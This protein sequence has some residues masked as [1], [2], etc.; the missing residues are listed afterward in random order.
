MT[1]CEFGLVPGPGLVAEC[2][3]RV[4]EAHSH[5]GRLEA[6]A[7]TRDRR[8][9]FLAVFGLKYGTA[10]DGRLAEL[11]GHVMD[12]AGPCGGFVP[13]KSCEFRSVDGSVSSDWPSDGGPEGFP[14]VHGDA[15][16]CVGREATG[17]GES[18]GFAYEKGYET[19][20]DVRR[21]V[22]M[23]RYALVKP[24]AK[25]AGWM[26]VRRDRCTYQDGTEHMCL[27]M[28]ERF[29]EPEYRDLLAGKGGAFA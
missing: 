23:V 12:W 2:L 17:S 5:R 6:L 25:G 7:G 15:M 9:L 4:L 27:S 22:V 11:G 18:S 21:R 8:D 29:L 16:A 26:A 1:E 3:E 10:N 20:V 19:Y 14:V 28:L 24:L 13:R